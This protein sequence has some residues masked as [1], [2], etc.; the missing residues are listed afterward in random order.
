MRAFPEE[1]GPMLSWSR[2][3]SLPHAVEVLTALSAFCTICLATNAGDS[4]EGQIRAALAMV[5][6]DRLVD[7]VYCFRRVGYKKPSPEFF[8]HVLADLGVSPDAVVMVGDDFEG[9]VLGALRCGIQA[10]W[11]NE[12]GAEDRFGEGY[13]TIHSLDQ[14]EEA[15]AALGVY[16]HR[17][18][19]E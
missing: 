5:G 1:V 2:V 13:R 12:G 4:D 9:D 6:L 15:L 3:E 10:I 11:L 16:A 19:E 17:Q 8:Q 18:G 7:R 14:L